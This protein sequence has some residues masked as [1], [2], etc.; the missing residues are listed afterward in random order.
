[1]RQLDD[2]IDIIHNSL[3]ALMKSWE[4]LHETIEQSSQKEPDEV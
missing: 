1:M 2:E 4:E 3:N